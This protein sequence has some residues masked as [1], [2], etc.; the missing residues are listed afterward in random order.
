MST[1]ALTGAGAG[2]SPAAYHPARPMTRSLLTVLRRQAA[3]EIRRGRLDEAEAVLAKLEEEDP[4][5]VETRG[6]RLEWLVRAGRLDDAGRLSAQLE[7]L[8]PSSPRVQFLAGRVRYERRDFAGAAA[9]FRESEALHPHPQPRLHLGRALTQL[10]DFD[11]AEAVLTALVAGTP[12]ARRDLAWLHERRGAHGRALEEVEHYLEHAPD[13]P[14]AKSQRLRLRARLAGPDELRHEVEELEELGEAP[15]PELAPEYVRALL[16]AGDVEGARSFLAEHG[17]ALPHHAVTKTAWE[18]Y[19]LQAHDLALGLFLRVFERHCANGK[20][21]A[22]L[23]AAA[24]RCGRLEA[25]VEPY[26]AHAERH[27]PLYGRLIR[28]RKALDAE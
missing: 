13:D 28:I 12:R 17:D 23:E 7:Q 6:L 15:A 19:K 2:G 1:P 27:R 16:A 10:G 4:L 3:S 24:R 22:A 25:L 8:F 9:R 18:A 21:L 11:A 26:E 14:L 5:A 20:F